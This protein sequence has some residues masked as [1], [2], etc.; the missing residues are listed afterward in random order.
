MIISMGYATIVAAVAVGVINL[1][2]G[3][4]RNS[5]SENSLYVPYLE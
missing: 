5:T 1:S 3:I 2:S 4:K